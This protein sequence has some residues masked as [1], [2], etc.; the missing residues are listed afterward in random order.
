MSKL[1]I[2]AGNSNP[3]LAGEIARR[4][5]MSLS[6]ATVET[7]RDGETRVRLEESVRGA[8]VFIVQ[9]VC[10]P[11][12]HNLI[13]LL[14]MIDAAERASAQRV[15]AV[16]PY[17][18]YAR[19]D[20]KRTGREPISA[21][22]VANLIA[23]AGADRVLTMDLHSPAIE[24]FFDIPVDHLRATP[25]MA[26]YF[27]ELRLSDLVVV[28]PDVG[29][30]RRANRFRQFINSA[31]A[32]AVVFKE[33]PERGAPE[34]LGI[35][36]EVGGKTA[37]IVDDLISTGETIIRAAE[38]LVERGAHPIYA[39]AV[40]PVFAPGAVESLEES[41][42]ERVFVTDTI[43]IPPQKHCDKIELVSMAPLLAK[44]IMYINKGLSMTTLFKEVEAEWLAEHRRG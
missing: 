29:G 43:P 25:I 22:L 3:T 26:D 39:C 17:F 7:F 37:V 33:R 20:R 38:I 27:C 19:Q 6:E 24:G 30:V 11:V 21:K 35:V 28:S 1:L 42:I 34:I 12:D 31:T 40:H 44:A 5:E 15:T 4:L 2:F 8:D 10:P 16:I 9:S 18:G 41:E 32:L 14:L 36:G 13:E 23:T